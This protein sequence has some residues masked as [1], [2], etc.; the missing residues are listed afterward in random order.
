MR[1][2]RTFLSSVVVCSTILFVVLRS[3]STVE[4]ADKSRND[5]EKRYATEQQISNGQQTYRY[6][7]PSLAELGARRSLPKMNKHILML[8][9]IPNAGG[10]LLVLIL[11][12]LQGYNAFKHIRLPPGD[13]GLL[14][15]LQEELLVEE[16]TNIIRQEAIPLT[17]D[18]D[19]RFLNFSK[20]GR[21]PPSFISLVRNPLHVQNVQRYHEKLKTDVEGRAIPTFCGQDPRCT[22]INNKWALQRAKANIVEEYPVVGILDCMEQSMNVLEHK[23]PYFFRGARDIYKKIRPKKEYVSDMSLALEPHDKDILLKLFEDEVEL[24]YW[25]KS[26]LFNETVNNLT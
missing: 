19:V 11:Q 16:I 13:H 4:F 26:R 12:R 23:F 8:T 21:Q 2:N 25:L 22:E 6:V 24:Y 20:F 5:I 14:S 17:F 15:S 18:G 3:K 7:T 1:I 10:E 9:R